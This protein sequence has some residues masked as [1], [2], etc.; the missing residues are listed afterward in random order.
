MIDK[1]KQISLIPKD[2]KLSKFEANDTS[3]IKSLKDYFQEE[4]VTKQVNSSLIAF[5]VCIKRSTKQDTVIVKA[6]DLTVNDDFEVRIYSTDLTA[7]HFSTLFNLFCTES[8]TIDTFKVNKLIARLND[9]K[10]KFIKSLLWLKMLIVD[11]IKDSNF[12]NIYQ[13]VSYTHLTLPTSD[14]V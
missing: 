5:T 14:L 1:M 13:A 6:K 8:K 3:N 10:S 7:K 9:S 4:R 2:Y 12:S 11:S